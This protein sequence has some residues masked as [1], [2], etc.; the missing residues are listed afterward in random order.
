M[1]NEHIVS[2][3]KLKQLKTLQLIYNILNLFLPLLNVH[4]FNMFKEG[5]QS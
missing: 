4:P 5:S 3:S 2:L 1:K